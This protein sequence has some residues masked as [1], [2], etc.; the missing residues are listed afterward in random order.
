MGSYQDGKYWD[1]LLGPDLARESIL[2]ALYVGGGRICPCESLCRF[3]ALGYIYISFFALIFPTVAAI[4]IDPLPVLLP[5]CQLSLQRA[6]LRNLRKLN[7]AWT[8]P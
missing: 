2:V 5:T 6:A 3:E 1:S 7:L 8:K 4:S